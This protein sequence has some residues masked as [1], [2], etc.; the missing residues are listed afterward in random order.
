MSADEPN[1]VVDWSTRR[2][3]ALE[4]EL[5]EAYANLTAT[6]TRCTELINE[7]R[8]QKRLIKQ[9]RARWLSVLAATPAI[10]S[11]ELEEEADR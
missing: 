9:I 2:I 7:T 8:A 3:K 5:R 6:Q 11:A 10:L 4:L 1:P